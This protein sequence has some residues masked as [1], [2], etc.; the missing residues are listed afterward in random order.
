MYGNL[1]AL[2]GAQLGHLDAYDIHAALRRQGEAVYST[3]DSECF[4]VYE[5]NC[6]HF[7]AEYY[8][9][10]KHTVH[11]KWERYFIDV[12][13]EEGVYVAYL[14]MSFKEYERECF[15]EEQQYI[16]NTAKREAKLN[17]QAAQGG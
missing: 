3:K 11:S 2:A 17:A 6:G 10:I 8:C 1:D 13:V 12:C 15:E 4:A 14:R 7:E 9:D 5:S 16:V